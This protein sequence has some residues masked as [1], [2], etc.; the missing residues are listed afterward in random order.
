LGKIL[1][2]SALPYANGDIHIGHLVEYIQTD[3]YVRF[4]KLLGEDV[5]Y[6]CASDAHGTPIEI[7]ARNRGITPEELVARY[8]RKHRED[9]DAF[10]I[11]FDEFYTTDSPE[12]RR[13][14]ETIYSRAEEKGHISIREIE[15]SF[16]TQ[17]GRFLPDRFIKGTCPRCRAAD[18]YGD[19]CESCGAT[20]Q[21]TD[22]DDAR[23]ALCGSTPSLRTS[24][25]FFF[26]LGDFRDFLAEWTAE[27]GRLQEAELAFVRNWIDQGLE[28]W[29]IS[30]D[31]PYF[32]FKIPGEEDKFFYV[33]LDAPIG[34]IA[35]TEKYCASRDDRTLEEYW[36]DHDSDAVIH[37]FIGK[38]IAYF[39]TLFWPATL[40][41][42]DY[43]LPSAVHVH[44]F[45]TVDGR[46][47][48]K[49]RGTFITARRF[50]E[51]LSPRHLRY[52][53]ATKFS[54][55]IDDL[56]LNAEEFVN[57]INA[58]LVNNIVNLISRAVGF[59]NKRLESRLGKTPADAEDLVRRVEAAV[60]TTREEYESLRFGRAVK[61]IL[62]ISDTANNYIQQ[63]E[64]W[65]VIKSDPERARDILTFAVNCV[66]IVTVLLKPILPEFCRKVEKILDV[67][68]L[69]W[70]DARF[71]MENRG[72]GRFEKL[73][74]RLEPGAFEKLIEESR[75]GAAE[76]DDRPAHEVPEF[77]DEITIDD[78][79]NMDLRAGKILSAEDVE[80][81]KKLLKLE[82]DLGREVRTV[83]AGI[84]GRFDPEEL[85][86]KTVTVLANL[87]PRKMRFGVSQGMILAGIDD[88]GNAGLCELN[89]EIPPGTR[90]S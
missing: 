34:Y 36:L 6:M 44:G 19:V 9:F 46:K 66:K 65:A 17:C 51:V 16:C 82:V 49:S 48:S 27:P 59:L 12:N 15:Q 24:K 26:K 89:P 88:H 85:V 20:Y 8:H 47:M 78:F 41:A 32:G 86:G 67:G 56:D 80:G 38:D 50:A 28:D 18:Q 58:E 30:R 61:Q 13:H 68:D 57:R 39:H 33:W 21:P 62:L 64:P 40:K 31:G 83:F 73:L 81:A 76:A 69:K 10:E 71:D 43:R 37:H 90:I 55:T 11:G 25:H 23:C 35:A 77:A 63:N 5:I 54:D 87:K 84:K 53:Y 7:N 45:L 14:C 60:D 52:Y 72:I 2:T 29:D 42:A 3:I 22:L 75:A 70:S 74:D 1:V 4:L 79:A